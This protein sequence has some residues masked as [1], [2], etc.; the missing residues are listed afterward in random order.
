MRVILRDRRERLGYKQKEIGD[1]LGL[2]AATI[3]NIESG[4]HSY[5][6]KDYEELLAKLEQERLHELIQVYP[7]Q[8]GTYLGELAF[9]R[10]AEEEP[11]SSGLRAA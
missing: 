7:R 6:V 10:G 2:S 8:A 3:S 5:F 4:Q 1:R 11:P 9:R